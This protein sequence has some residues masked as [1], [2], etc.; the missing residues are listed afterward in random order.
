MECEKVKKKIDEYLDEASNQVEEFN[1]DLITKKETFQEWH[2][3]VHTLMRDRTA[4][5]KIKQKKTIAEE[6][7]EHTDMHMDSCKLSSDAVL[8]VNG[9]DST[10][11]TI[12][13]KPYVVFT[14]AQ[15]VLEVES[16]RWGDSC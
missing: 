1:A 12:I 3:K 14:Q 9:K 7:K 16:F 11:S 13:I 5:D 6:L 8:V 4:K 2:N 15:S 10:L